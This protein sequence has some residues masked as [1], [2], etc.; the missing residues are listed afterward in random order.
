MISPDNKIVL[1]D[2]GIVVENN[3]RDYALIS[4]I[5]A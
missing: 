2:V 5:L 3:E 4:D 1:L